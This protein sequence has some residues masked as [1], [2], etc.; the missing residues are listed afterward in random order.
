MKPFHRVSLEPIEVGRMIQDRV[1]LVV[2]RPEIGRRIARAVLSAHRAHEVLPE[3]YVLGGELF[4]KCCSQI[5][6]DLV[7]EDTTLFAQVLAATVGLISRSYTRKNPE[8]VKVLIFPSDLSLRSQSSAFSF[9]LKPRLV[10][11]LDAPFTSLNR[12]D[13]IQQPFVLSL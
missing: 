12:Q 10:V 7:L 13:D 6:F 1:E 2:Y 5:R 3:Q 8:R 11:L 9:V 4:D